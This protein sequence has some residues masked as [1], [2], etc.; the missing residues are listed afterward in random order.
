MV[1]VDTAGIK[2]KRKTVDAVEKIMSIRSLNSLKKADVAILVIDAHEGATHN[3]QQILRHIIQEGRASVIAAN[4]VDLIT[5]DDLGE[6]NLDLQDSFHF[7]KYVPLVFISAAGK[8]GIGR[9]MK[10]VNG[11][12]SQYVK[13]V[14]TSELNREMG[15]SLFTVNIPGSRTPNRAYY[16]TQTSVAPP[17]FTLFVKNP[18]NI[19]ESF[20][21][22]VTNR[23]RDA[24]GFGGCPIR[25][26]YRKK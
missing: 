22:Y 23:L 19:P 1:F 6:V 18:G 24:F 8:T 15:D 26:R 4:K 10:E 14:K 5:G 21:R 16:I 7:A 2:P 9:L 13:R 11:V 17:T 12:F 25:I 3:D 20:T